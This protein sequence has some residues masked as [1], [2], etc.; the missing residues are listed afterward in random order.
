LAPLAVKLYFFIDEIYVTPVKDSLYHTGLNPK[1]NMA[2]VPSIK[3]LIVDDEKDICFL[4]GNILKQANIQPVLAGSIKEAEKI[5]QAP[6]SFYYIFLDN[7]LP[8]GS[9]I[10][11]VKKWKE[12]YPLSHLIMI[13]AH[14]SYEERNKA[15]GDGVDHFISKPF[16]REVILN[17]LIPTSE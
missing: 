3:A 4:L 11:Q 14:D 17:T 13:T 15:V 16:S 7:H 8:D 6:Q 5:L 1:E 2:N 10:N 12:K 9:G